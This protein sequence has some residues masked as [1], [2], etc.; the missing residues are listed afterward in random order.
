MVQST[1]MTKTL[2]VSKSCRWPLKNVA[3]VFILQNIKI[4]CYHFKKI[5]LLCRLWSITVLQGRPV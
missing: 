5:A 2:D 4:S 3:W 1:E